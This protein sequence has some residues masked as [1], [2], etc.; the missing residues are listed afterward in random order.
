MLFLLL[1]AT[2]MFLFSVLWVLTDAP[3]HPYYKLAEIRI[4]FMVSFISLL[5]YLCIIF[6]SALEELQILWIFFIIHGVYMVSCLYILSAY[7][8]KALSN[9][10][11]LS[12][13]VIFVWI[14]LFVLLL[15]NMKLITLG[16]TSKIIIA[17]FSCI[18][19]VIILFRF[20][21]LGSRLS[22]YAIGLKLLY[23]IIFT[24]YFVIWLSICFSPSVKTDTRHY[25]TVYHNK[26]T[27]NGISISGRYSPESSISGGNDDD[28]DIIHTTS[29]TSG[30]NETDTKSFSN[31]L[32]DNHKP[33]VSHSSPSDTIRESFVDDREKIKS[34]TSVV[35]VIFQIVDVSFIFLFCIV[36]LKT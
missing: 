3:K 28:D 20:L 9:P 11:T 30:K 8:T 19:S 15:V 16:T 32:R 10:I 27:I 25:N 5:L 21:Q 36:I 33:T 13:G 14:A 31:E 1:H 6:D 4:F 34:F 18:L 2:I 22:M 7:Y 29:T 17:V 24:F 35:I 23:L 26:E 12:I